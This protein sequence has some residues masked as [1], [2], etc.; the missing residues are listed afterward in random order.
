[1]GSGNVIRIAR[2]VLVQNSPPYQVPKEEVDSAHSEG[3]K[4]HLHSKFVSPILRPFASGKI[5]KR[6]RQIMEAF[7]AF[8]SVLDAACGTDRT[9]VDL[10]NKY[11]GADVYANDLCWGYLRQLAR[12]DSYR[13]IIF[14]NQNLGNF[15]FRPNMSFDVI[16]FKNTLHHLKS[17]EEASHIVGQLCSIGKHVLIVDIEN[18]SA[19]NMRAAISHQYY[20]RWLKDCGGLFFSW[21]EFRNLVQLAARDRSVDFERLSTLKG[22]YMFAVVQPLNKTAAG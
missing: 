4:Y 8:G 18:P 3:W 9:I 15:W 11:P 19:S 17:L 20:K 12:Y 13:R 7:P 10:S 2:E 6:V 16:L 14:L 22:R 1:M 21:D 5:V